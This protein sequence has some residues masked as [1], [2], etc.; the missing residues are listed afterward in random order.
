[1]RI[2]PIPQHDISLS[3]LDVGSVLAVR[4][5]LLGIISKMELNDD[6]IAPDQQLSYRQCIDSIGLDSIRERRVSS[7]RSVGP[8]PENL[9]SEAI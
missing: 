8:S 9:E 1:M 4:M 7:Q 5:L 3:S 6:N 2:F